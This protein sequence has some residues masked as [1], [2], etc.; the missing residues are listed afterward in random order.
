MVRISIHAPRVGGDPKGPRRYGGRGRIS[1]H[2][3][4]VGGDANFRECRRQNVLFQ[5]TPPVWGA[6]IPASVRCFCDLRFQST[7]PVWGATRDLGDGHVPVTYFNPRPP[8]GGRPTSAPAQEPEINISIHAPRVGG[9]SRW[10]PCIP[11]TR[12]FNPRPPCG[13]RLPQ[14][15]VRLIQQGISIHAP[16]V[17][18]DC[19]PTPSQP[20]RNYFNPRPPC[21]GR[22]PLPAR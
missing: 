14:D 11:P 2:A 5:S 3:P 15:V 4:R 8:C 1:I 18:G 9:D 21:G 10:G 7:P 6:T 13:G 16:R 20:S 17:G 19:T 12:H 22:L